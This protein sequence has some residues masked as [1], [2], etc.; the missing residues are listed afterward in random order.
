MRDITFEY[1]GPAMMVLLT[2]AIYIVI[3]VVFLNARRKYKGGIVEKVIN[4]IIATIGFLLVADLALFMMPLYGFDISY[5]AHVVFKIVAM[6]SLS[7]GGLKFF[8]K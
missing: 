2:M 1:L 5:T 3:I 4:F 8:V 7:I 6:T